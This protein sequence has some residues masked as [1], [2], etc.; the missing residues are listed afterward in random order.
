VNNAMPSQKAP[1]PELAA[2][3]ARLREAIAAVAQEDARLDRLEDGHARA[4]EESWHVRSQLV[5]A[6]DALRKA[7]NDAPQRKVYE[8][9]NGD[10]ALAADPVA[11]AETTAEAARREVARIDEL[12]TAL[13]AEIQQTQYRVQALRRELYEAMA[14][15]VTA[16]PEYR[17]LIDDHRAT[18]RHLRS[19]KETL[20]VLHEALHGQYPDIELI[21]LI[22]PLAV[23]VGYPVEDSVAQWGEALRRLERDADAG[24]PG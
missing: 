9:L 19:L 24:L 16:S 20:R 18:W 4:R 7:A 22:E 14:A 15:V 6:E 17:A 11:E 1:V 8:Y 21:S 3:R 13:T 23:R 5:D 2:L 10:I 12:E